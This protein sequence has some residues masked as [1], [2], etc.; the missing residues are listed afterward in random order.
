MRRRARA[1]TLIELLVVI[2]L[3]GILVSLAVLTTG[4]SSTSR[5]LRDEARRIAALIGVLSDEAVLDSREYGLLVNREGYRVLRYDEADARWREV[6]RR[7]VHRLPEWMRLELELDGT[8]LE[9][10][11]PV[12][13]ADDRAGLSDADSRG[14]SRERNSGP[15]L[16]PQLLILSSGEL[17]P[18]S[19][20][21]SERKAG[22]STW[23]IASD[24]LRLPQAELLEHRR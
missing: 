12:R 16:E 9:L 22:G 18:F 8:P 3:L 13:Q 11:A 20:R 2:V 4:S 5:E 15:R 1:F 23:L 7:K 19:L 10:V 24:G 14:R 6:E 17:S 21:L